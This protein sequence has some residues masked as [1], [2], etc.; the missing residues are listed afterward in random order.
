MNGWKEKK[1]ISSRESACF[2]CFSQCQSGNPWGIRQ[3]L[4]LLQYEET[5]SAF[6]QNGA[7]DDGHSA[8]GVF[9]IT[10]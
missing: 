6:P 9:Q 8:E 3:N 10:C 2:R 1:F 4:P 5:I 7:Y